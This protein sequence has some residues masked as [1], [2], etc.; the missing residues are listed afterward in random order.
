MKTIIDFAEEKYCTRQ[1]IYDAMKLNKLDYVEK[2]GKRLVQDTLKN[3]EWL[4]QKYGK[5]RNT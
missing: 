1:A 4:P 3:S 5:H 2:F